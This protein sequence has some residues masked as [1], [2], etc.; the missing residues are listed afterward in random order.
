LQLGLLSGLFLGCFPH[1]IWLALQ[2]QEN[3]LLGQ[4]PMEDDGL[5]FAV[6]QD[7]LRTNE[8]QLE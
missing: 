3:A 8:N 2:R 6:F 4:G 5:A 1:A 7:G